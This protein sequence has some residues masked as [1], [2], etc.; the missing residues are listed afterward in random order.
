[1]CVYTST[2]VDGM[3]NVSIRLL[4]LVDLRVEWLDPL[5]VPPG[6]QSLTRSE[7]STRGKGRS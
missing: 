7:T 6:S 3:A 1:M 4:F 5:T 2:R